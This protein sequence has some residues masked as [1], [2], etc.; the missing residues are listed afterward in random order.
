V[1]DELELKSRAY[2]VRDK[3]KSQGTEECVRSCGRTLCLMFRPFTGVM[4]RDE[5]PGSYCRP[6]PF[7][8]FNAVCIFIITLVPIQPPQPHALNNPNAHPIP[9]P[10]LCS[11]SPLNKQALRN[12]TQASSHPD[13]TPHSRIDS[14]RAKPHLLLQQKTVDRLPLVRQSCRSDNTQ[15]RRLQS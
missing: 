10:I 15:D 3:L 9:S 12:S 8:S 14:K 13:K 1:D 2:R 5:V 7:R 4:Q 11:A 6:S